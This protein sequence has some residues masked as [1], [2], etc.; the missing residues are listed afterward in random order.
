M[1]NSGKE[2][3]QIPVFKEKTRKSLILL[4]KNP[5]LFVREEVLNFIDETNKDDYQLNFKNASNT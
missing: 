5:V 4:V 1:I 2:K 3:L